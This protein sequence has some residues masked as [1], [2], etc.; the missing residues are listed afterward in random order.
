MDEG[1]TDGGSSDMAGGGA[2]E[3]WCRAG[4]E[5][6]KR[7]RLRGGS[8]WVDIQPCEGRSRDDEGWRGLQGE[9][10]RVGWCVLLELGSS[11]A[12]RVVR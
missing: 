4:S 7:R 3:L 12:V 1:A 6:G 8:L 5:R 10:V 11:R 2:T 9:R